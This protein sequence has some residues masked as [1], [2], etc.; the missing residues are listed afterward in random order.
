MTEERARIAVNTL[1]SRNTSG[2][3]ASL[4]LTQIKDAPAITPDASA[5]SMSETQA[6][7]ARVKFASQNSM[8]SPMPTRR[9][10]V[11]EQDAEGLSPASSSGTS[12]PNSE[13][14]ATF[15]IEKV[16]ANRLLFWGRLSRGN[17]HVDHANAVT[18]LGEDLDQSGSGRNE[19]VSLDSMI[20]EGRAGQAGSL[21]S[22]LAQAA[23][24][25]ATQAEKHMEL[26]DKIV[27][28]CVREF[29]RGGM[30]FAY[31]FGMPQEYHQVDL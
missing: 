11:S 9:D 1:A 6:A 18:S 25:P 5:T 10:E 4:I 22:I 2:P 31:T 28:E 16:L 15:P 8:L 14:L 12:T 19:E 7:A 13:T 21:D 17:S 26:E 20:K 3:R 29:S 24:A 23:P 27:R 30:Y